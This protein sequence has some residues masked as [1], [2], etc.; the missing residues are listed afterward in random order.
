[1]KRKMLYAL[2]ISMMIGLVGCGKE[3]VNDN[4][5]NSQSTDTNV[6]TTVENNNV[7]NDTVVGNG[8]LKGYF[9][10]GNGYEDGII[11]NDEEDGNYNQQEEEN[12]GKEAGFLSD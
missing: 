11:S 1:M 6:S 7:T 9:Y 4:T 10:Y 8:R 12:N 5:S 2:M 3:N